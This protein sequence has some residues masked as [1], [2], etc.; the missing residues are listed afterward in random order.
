VQFLG[1]GHD[2]QTVLRGACTQ[3]NQTWWRH[4]AIIHT[5]EI[6]FSVQMYCCIFKCERL[7]FEWCWKRRQTYDRTSEIPLMAIHCVAAERGGLIKKKERQE[8]AWVILK[9]SRLRSGGQKIRHR[10]W[11]I[12]MRH[13]WHQLCS[14]YER[15]TCIVLDP[16][17]CMQMKSFY[18]AVWYSSHAVYLCGVLRRMQ[19]Q[20]T[21]YRYSLPRR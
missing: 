4:R 18:G 13:L 7:K 16:W 6:C 14:L 3:H 11:N 2:W 10:I 8:S 9:A 21:M 19:Q 12:K 5:Q 17:C 15:F 20:L 1:V